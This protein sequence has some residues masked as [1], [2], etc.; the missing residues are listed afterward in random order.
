MNIPSGFIFSTSSAVAVM[1]TTVTS[2]FKS[3]SILKILCFMPQSYATTLYFFLFLPTQTYFR[4]QV[5][6]PTSFNFF[7]H[8]YGFAVDTSFARSMPLIDCDAF[9]F[10]NNDFL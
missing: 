9:T 5:S 10:F 3:A 2:Q 6:M 7:V 8:L 4:S 1:G